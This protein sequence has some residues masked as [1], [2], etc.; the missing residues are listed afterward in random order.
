MEPT[1]PK[2]KNNLSNKT[3]DINP[4]AAS[5]SATASPDHVGRRLIQQKKIRK[6]LGDVS[7]MW[8]HR[9]K[10]KLPKPILIAGRRFWL[11]EEVDAY[12]E[13]LSTERKP[14]EIQRPGDAS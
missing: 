1:M 13:R 9:H 12:I 8:L 7:P 10:G 4:S 2:P 14:E 6:K 5:S 3:C 11:E